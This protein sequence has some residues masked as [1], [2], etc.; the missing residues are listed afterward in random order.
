MY[1][2][3]IVFVLRDYSLEMASNQN[4]SPA[5]VI[6]LHYSVSTPPATLSPL[7]WHGQNKE[8]EV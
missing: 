8:Q 7:L 3:I 4:V 6:L 1:D 2:S 5:P